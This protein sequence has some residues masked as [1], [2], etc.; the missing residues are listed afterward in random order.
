MDEEKEL[1]CTFTVFKLER[2]SQGFISLQQHDYLER[3]K[4]LP[5]DAIWSC[6]VSI[7]MRLSF[8]SHIQLDCLYELS[9][10]IQVTKDVL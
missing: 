10:L 1:P 9:Q 3:P 7:R 2:D 6:L 4:L 8:L 5:E